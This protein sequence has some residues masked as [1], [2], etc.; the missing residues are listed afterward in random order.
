MEQLVKLENERQELLESFENDAFA[1]E[2]LRVEKLNIPDGL[3]DAVEPGDEPIDV[4]D[5]PEE[6]AKR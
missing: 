6:S 3:M 5:L 2:R 4:P 1:L